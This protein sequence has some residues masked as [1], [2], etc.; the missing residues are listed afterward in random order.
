MNL[1]YVRVYFPTPDGDLQ[2]ETSCLEVEALTEENAMD[3]VYQ[4]HPSAVIVDVS[5]HVDEDD[6]D[7]DDDLE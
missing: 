4:H 3:I 5:P 7:E 6:D 1:Y 2:D